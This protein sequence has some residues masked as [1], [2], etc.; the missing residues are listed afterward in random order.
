MQPQS[1]QPDRR[2]FVP[3][4][5]CKLA[6]VSFE[7]W[8]QAEFIDLLEL[9]P[10]P[11][12]LVIGNHNTH[13]LFLFSRSAGMRQFYNRC[14]MTF[15]DGMPLIL[16]ARMLGY[17]A[18][19]DHRFTS[20]D[21]IKPFFERCVKLNKRVFLLGSRPEVIPKAVEAFQKLVPGVDL[22]YRH[23]FFD[24]KKDSDENRQIL[25]QINESGADVLLVGMGM[26]RQEVWIVENADSLKVQMIM[27]LGAFMDYFAG[28]SKT[29]P[30]F[31]GRLGL[32]WAYRL[33]SEPRRLG[34]RYL[35]EPWFVGFR[36]LIK[37]GYRLFS[38]R[39]FSESPL[40]GTTQICGFD[41][42]C[43]TYQNN[44][45]KILSLI[46]SRKGGWILTLNLESVSRARI[47]PNYS[48]LVHSADMVVAD[49]MPLIWGSRLKRGVP[50]I[51]E[52]TAGSDLTA[53][54]I[55]KTPA[56][57][58]AIIGGE[59]PPQALEMLRIKKASEVF[60]FDGK[61]DTSPEFMENLS[62]K[63]EAHGASL[64]FLALGAPKQDKAAKYLRESLPHAVLVGVGGSF[65]LI[66]GIKPRAPKWMR[67]YGL[68]WLF[69][70]CLEPRRLWHRYLVLYWVGG[71]HMLGD[72]GSSFFRRSQKPIEPRSSE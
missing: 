18:R 58:I 34:Y 20:I 14:E 37:D 11:K 23:G 68:E 38:R 3:K 55:L 29:P 52:R 5:K 26:P 49:G 66:A 51:P 44:L 42:R 60:V 48:R 71:F 39:G 50:A 59:N 27:S 56:S 10:R 54:L 36:F 25:N 17:P 43:D 15:V 46:K 31:L 33:Y 2:E 21:F 16:L 40:G 53:D 57:K 4:P 61:V 30:R 19:R 35:V 72:I 22:V 28:A 67:R 64:I 1:D 47:D 69:R 45:A 8:T 13:S 65:D 70:L 62:K 12:P 63:I 7:L 9:S 24:A 6:G 41:I 32:E